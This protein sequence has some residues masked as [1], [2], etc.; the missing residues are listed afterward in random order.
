MKQNTLLKGLVVLAGVFLLS[1]S[2]AWAEPC[3]ADIN[4]NGRVG[5]GDVG[6][7]I[8]EWGKGVLSPCDPSTQ[9]LNCE[10]FGLIECGDTCV[11]NSTDESNCGSCGNTCE[12]YE[13]CIA[14][15]CDF[16]C[17][18]GLIKCS[19][20]CVDNSTDENNCGSC[21]NVCESGDMCVAG[22]CYECVPK[23]YYASVEKTGQTTSSATGDDGDLEMGVDWPTPR[24][25][26]NMDGTV[27]DHLTGFMWL[28]DA[29]CIEMRVPSFDNDGTAG[30]GRVTWQHA[31]DFIA[32]INDSTYWQCGAGYNDWRLPNRYE[33][34]SLLDMSNYNPPLPSGHPFISVQTDYYWSGTSTASLSYVAWYVNLTSGYVDGSNMSFD[35][36]VWPVRG[37][38]D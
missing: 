11:D 21:G 19:D 4:C 30:D 24:F 13:R 2:T 38:N 17:P 32:G 26:N 33:L 35:Y 29:N 22:E 31:L 9:C 14:G 10:V 34:E 36:Y 16:V 1:A 5:T 20:T 23:I 37:G 12:S 18:P 28:I 15:V 3:R 7:I 8:Q 27:T 6:W 25:T